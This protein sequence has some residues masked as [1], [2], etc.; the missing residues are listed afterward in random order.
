M[1]RRLAVLLGSA[2]LLL[3]LVEPAGQRTGA[4]ARYLLAMAAT[5]MA[6]PAQA[7]QTPELQISAVSA[8]VTEGEEA[9]FTVT[10]T[11]SGA[12]FTM[13]QLIYY[14]ATES[15]K[16]VDLIQQQPERAYDGNA[17]FRLADETITITVPTN[18]DFINEDNSIL[19]VTLVAPPDDSGFEDSYTVAAGSGSA[20]VTIT[21]DDDRGV[22]I[23]EP[24]SVRL[25]ENGTTTYSLQ[26]SSAPN[27]DVIITPDYDTTM[28]TVSPPSLTIT[29]ADWEDGRRVVTVTGVGN[30]IVN[31]A[32]TTI[33]HSVSG[34]GTTTSAAAVTVTFDTEAPTV[35]AIERQEPTASPTNADSLTWR[36]TF[37]EAVTNL[38]REDFTVGD[39][40]SATLSVEP[41][42]GFTT[43][44][45]VTLRDSGVPAEVNIGTQVRDGNLENLDGTVT[46][47]FANDQNIQDEAGNA[48]AP[49]PPGT[50]YVVDNTAPVVQYQSTELPSS[51]TVGTAITEIRPTTTGTDIA[52]YSATGLPAGLEINPSTGVISGTPTMATEG[53]A[54][55]VTVT[56][57]AGNT[58]EF[59]FNLPL[60][61]PD[62]AGLPRVVSIERQDPTTSPTNANTLTWRFT[63]SE[64][65]MNVDE[66]DFSVFGG[67]G[68]MV[69]SVQEASGAINAYDVTVSGGNLGNLDA[70]VTLVFDPGLLNIQDDEGNA[71]RIELE[72]TGTN[73]ASYEIDNTL[74]MVGYQEPEPL[75]VGT[76]TEI[77]P[78]TDDSDIASYSVTSGTLP[79]GLM[80]DEMTGVISGTPTT[81]TASTST[82]MVTAPGTPQD[83][84]TATTFFT[85][86]AT[87]TVTDEAGNSADVTITFP[88]VSADATAP[89]LTSIERQEPATSPTNADS[90]TW[91][92]TFSEAVTGVDMADFT[93]NG[94]DA[95]L[96]VEEVTGE[97][98]IWDVTASGG[99]LATLNGTVTIGL[100]ATPS[101]T[102]QAAT[103]NTLT[104]TMPTT[105]TNE[106][107]DVDNTPP[108]TMPTYT[109]PSSLTVGTEITVTPSTTDTDIAS[110]SA[111]G[112]PPGLEIDPSTGVISGTPT[113]VN[114]STSTTMVTAMDA[115]GN[116]GTPVTLTFPAVNADTTPPMVT[117]TAPSSLTVGTAITVTPDTDDTD[118]TSYSVT[119]GTLPAGLTID[120]TTGVISGTPTT[121]NPSSTVMV[122]VTDNTG[123]S[124][125]PVTLT[126]PAVVEVSTTPP[127]DT[128]PLMVTYTA[129]SSL[130][131]GTAITEIRPTNTDP[132]ITSYSATGLPPGLEIDPSTG[133][134]SGSP[135][136]V[137]TSMSTATV[138]VTDNTGNSDTVTLTFPAVT[139]ADRPGVRVSPRRL[140]LTEQ[141][142]ATYTVALNTQP[143][144]AVTITPNS[145]ASDAVSVSPAS[146]TFTANNWNMPQT[147]TVT[148][149]P[150][151]DSDTDSEVTITHAV[152]GA[153]YDSVTAHPVRVIVSD[154]KPAS[155]DEAVVPEVLQQVTA[156]TTEVIISR[157]SSIASGLPSAPPTLSLEKVLVDTVA[158]FHGERDRLKDG[159]MGWQQAFAGRDF[160]F[161][162]SGLTL[163]QGEGAS[164]QE[165]PFSSLA[166][167]GGG[168]YSSYGNTIDGTEIDGDGFSGTIGIDLQ[169][170][171][172]LVSGLA[173]TTSRWGLDYT[174]DADVEG[175]YD[176]GVTMVNPYVSWLATDQLSL[177]GTF[178]YG[179]GEVEQT[180]DGEDPTSP[181]TDSLTSWAGGL[182]FEASPGADPLTGEGSFPV[183]LAFKVDGAASS[184]LNTD[185]QL[186]RLAAEA[187]RSFT[188]ENGLLTAALELGWSIRGASDNDD[189]SGGGAEL[190]GRLHWLNTGGSVSATVESRVLL[191]DGDRR[192]WGLG[193]HLRLTPSKRGGEGLSL[194]LQPSF[195]VTGTQLDELWSLSED[196][197]LAISSDQ[198]SGRLDAR[199][200][201]GFRHGDALLTPYT[202]VAWEEAAS[203]YRAGLRYA[204][205]ASLELD[206]K[207]THRSPTSGNTENHV[208]LHMRSHL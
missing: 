5:T 182:R 170:M 66:E 34:Y 107:Y 37:S 53:S 72:P 145:G 110:Y 81:V 198:P 162:L 117:Y 14:Q 79:P 195:G 115:A 180:P 70:T 95:T 88:A 158:A 192:E 190:A 133:V 161:P 101:I 60:V 125:T 134:I 39:A 29:P 201:Y 64:A 103:P 24:A 85:S 135:T 91:R 130:T 113:M 166:I 183:A 8:T 40:T 197:D 32:M 128:T 87:V 21:D 104:D 114:P 3:P 33:S 68:I 83:G 188:V 142:T 93:V 89:T 138:T 199:L 96:S 71:L 146:L 139:A 42:D 205:N 62:P 132:D 15:G 127:T 7:Q 150:M 31:D 12:P 206:L 105:G 154:T 173:L 136:T 57:T 97:T 41:V 140:D 207:G 11:G 149:T 61:S 51:L 184:F 28:V 122:T 143:T 102:D 98:G 58:G 109:A 2:A 76:A 157:L 74:P 156:Q 179:R 126:F 63:F 175:T 94:T 48:L 144:G 77:L 46:L 26:L 174:T 65:V 50:S 191:G 17:S 118:I 176:I 137:N 55:R 153:D 147:V 123:N 82:E 193:G 148:V 203:T 35:T 120:S 30:T 99:N 181:R 59:P 167:W 202:E 168:D 20:T 43:A 155:L 200:A 208:F 129:P 23:V 119:S 86:T 9:M 152:S 164:A 163:A 151:E 172:K 75:E 194:T 121:A 67:S 38:D 160:A 19:T 56:D 49:T 171:P 177:W 16:M 116:S 10:S 80:I 92:V 52:S 185:V 1:V 178:G 84:Q 4:V 124:G 100:V 45:D 54:L 78:I 196:G 186:A 165:N 204:L 69:T 108:T 44:Y 22:V 112:L 90:L 73:D 36:V 187:S 106:E 189:A 13:T 131:V 6:T 18:D 169:P 47:A 159:S 111:T 141:E 27:T 25:G